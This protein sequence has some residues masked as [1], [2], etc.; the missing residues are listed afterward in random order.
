[1]KNKQSVTVF[2]LYKL[3]Y[4]NIPLSLIAC[5]GLFAPGLQTVFSVYAQ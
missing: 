2:S 5:L 3:L 1:M 4:N